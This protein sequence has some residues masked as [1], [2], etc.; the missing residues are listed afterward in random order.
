MGLR[1]GREAGL[2]ENARELPP[3]TV[4]H[5]SPSG[6]KFK[7]MTGRGDDWLDWDTNMFHFQGGSPLDASMS[8]YENLP[9]EHYFEE[10]EQSRGL[11][12]A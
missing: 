8:D 3:R 9:V 4:L 1:S 7:E 12:P 2:I 10:W 6:R 5:I 11:E